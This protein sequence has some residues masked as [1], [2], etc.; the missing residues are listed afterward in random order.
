MN[1]DYYAAIDKM[2]K[3]KVS[4]EYIVGWASGYLNNPKVEEQR[5]NDAYEAGYTDGEEKNADNFS[6]W[7]G[8]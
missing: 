6:A 7:E 8:K 4:R 3:A 2:E 1:E 5:V